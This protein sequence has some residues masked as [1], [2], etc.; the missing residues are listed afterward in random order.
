M[1][2]PRITPEIKQLIIWVWWEMM[3][4]GQEPIAKKVINSVSFRLK[5]TNKNNLHVPGIRKTQEILRLARKGLE[6]RPEE[7]KELDTPWSIGSTLKHVINTE[8]M[9]AVLR[10]WKLYF[11]AG[12]PFT[13]REARWVAQLHTLFSD[14]MELRD[15]AN[16]YAEKEQISEISKQLFKN[17]EIFGI[18]DLDAKIVMDLWEYATARQAGQISTSLNPIEN[19]P[20]IRKSFQTNTGDGKNAMHFAMRMAAQKQ[21]FER[22]IQEVIQNVP[23][24]IEEIREWKAKHPE[25]EE[26]S[27][28]AAWIYAHWLTYLSKGPK[29]S[30]LSSLETIDIE[31]KLQAWVLT[32]KPI[33]SFEEKIFA[34]TKQD[35]ASGKSTTEMADSYH[36]FI[37]NPMKPEVP[38]A[39]LLTKVGYN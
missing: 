30:K 9:P 18:H 27:D 10:V 21:V 23:W 4:R 37:K 19:W 29:W 28:Q 17:K 39:E 32:L 38:P 34:L 12:T 11:A 14:I 1:G 5:A 7:Q 25:L 31:Y 35:I 15:I 33:E 26:L 16:M 6:K 36:N 2:G 8:A 24:S 20:M 3:Q 13:I 22:D